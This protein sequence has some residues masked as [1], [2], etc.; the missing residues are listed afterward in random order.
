MGE[1]IARA[2]DGANP[3]LHSRRSAMT[4]AVLSIGTE[5]TRGE[6]VNSNAAWLGDQLTSLGLEVRQH[7]TVDDDVDRIA[8]AL[9]FL[10]EEVQVVVATGGLGPTS[11][12][13]TTAAVAR[14]LDVELVRDAASWEAIQ[15]RY[16]ARGRTPTEMHAKQADFPRGADVLPNREGTAPGFAVRRNEARAF[17][18]PGVPREM[19]AMFEQSVL[20]AVADLARRDSYQ[21]HVRLFGLPESD[22]ASRLEELEGNGITLAFRASFPEIEVKVHARATTPAEAEQRAKTAAQRV[23]DLLGEAVFGDRQDQFAAVI[24]QHLRDRGL[25]LAVAE[26][27]TGGMVGSMLTDVPGSSDYLLLDA[28][29]YANSAKT[30]VLGVG[31]DVLRGYGAVSSETASAMAE[32]AKRVSGADVGVSTTGVAGPG[33]GTDAKPVGTV[34]FGLATENGTLTLR[35]HFHGDREQVRMQAAYVALELVRRF[36]LGRDPANGPAS[37]TCQ[38][39]RPV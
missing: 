24:G 14:A 36:A 21:V 9:R 30:Q 20:P 15:K 16:S 38:E 27:C 31:P 37:R 33:G 25:T 39:V 4:A 11:D 7:I 1:A 17:F 2:V 23:R 10:S 8:A 22:V 34:W 32:G 3:G 12:D 5:L 26:S 18:L 19:K 28:V 35:H 29:T 6:L 13:L